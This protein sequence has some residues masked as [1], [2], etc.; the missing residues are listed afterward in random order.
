ME[1]PNTNKTTEFKNFGTVKVALSEMQGWRIDMEDAHISVAL[2]G[3]DNHYIFGVFDG[4]AGDRAAK[5]A[6]EHLVDLLVAT[7]EYKSYLTE[8]QPDILAKALTQSFKDFDQKIYQEGIHGNSG[9]TS[10]VVV[11]TPDSIICANAGDSRAIMGT[12]PQ[13][14]TP[15]SFDHKPSDDGESKRI[16]ESGG[17]VNFSR[18]DGELAVSRAFGDFRY[19]NQP[20]VFSENKV[21][22]VP[23]I[24]INENANNDFIVIACD[25]L[26]DVFSNE[27]AILEVRKQY[28]H[29]SEVGYLMNAPVP[30]AQDGQEPAKILAETEEDKLK[31]LVEHMLNK[32]LELGSKDNISCIIVKL[33]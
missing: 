1:T 15:L 27:D 7:A 33:N 10:C 4:H 5:L 17:F 20:L 29:L 18:V 2:P 24:T 21:I 11:V 16:T 28:A 12:L 26:W 32:S 8:K 31:V 3:L 6:A 25:G 14:C 30:V 9:C 19:K 23:D 13:E 22:C